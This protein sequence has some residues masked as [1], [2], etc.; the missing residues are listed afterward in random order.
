MTLSLRGTRRFPQSAL[1]GGIALAA[2]AALTLTGCSADTAGASGADG[3]LKV[4]ATT[5]QLTD[6]A[7]EIGGDDI[8]LRG[9]LVP[10]GSAHHFDPTP[11]DLLALSEAD[12]L[13]VNGAGL[14]SFIDDAI[15]ASGFDGE[16]IT[17]SDGIDLAEAT[18]I[19][20]EGEAGGA[21]EHDHA[22]HDHDHAAEADHDHAAEAEH[23][24]AAD[25]AEEPE[26]A[27]TDHDGHDHGATNPHL[28]TSP[29]YAEGMAAHIGE[30][31]ARIDTANAADYDARTAAYVQQLQALDTWVSEQFAAVP[32]AKRVLVSGHDSLRYFLHDYDI[33][34]AGAILPSFEDNAEPSA[35]DIDALVAAIKDR[36]VTAVFVESSMSP[37]LAR[38]I[39]AE[40]GVRV[41]DAESLYAD[42]LGVADSG[43]DTYIS[44]TVH[45]TRTILEA[46]GETTAPLPDTL[47]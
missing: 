28:W 19:T 9:L 15:D 3:S 18:E 32:E 5:T 47:Q 20:A 12:V 31:F 4:V 37:K 40:A 1:L 11:A 35:A 30:E 26:A 33:D 24:H 44:A 43:A 42:S 34:F 27:H 7:R 16:V 14:E 25:V 6:F 29:R 2:A 21:A 36:G 10:G 17:A 46:W 22:D 13:I 41:I 38:T 8:E 23:D 39:A 45:N